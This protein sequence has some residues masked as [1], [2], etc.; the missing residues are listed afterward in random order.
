VAGP[1][2]F[3]ATLPGVRPWGGRL[4]EKRWSD[5]PAVQ[6]VV[7][8]PVLFRATVLPVIGRIP[9]ARKTAWPLT[10]DHNRQVRVKRCPMVFRA[11][12]LPVIGRTPPARKTLAGPPRSAIRRGPPGDFSRNSAGGAPLGPPA[13]KTAWPITADHNRQGL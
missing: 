4:H 3:R 9:P 10:A 7:A 5:I 8:R 2:I 12:V 13:R 1:V 6:F 11:T